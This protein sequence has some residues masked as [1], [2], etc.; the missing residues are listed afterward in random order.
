MVEAESDDA[1]AV[2]K[3]LELND[4]INTI[5]EKYMLVRKGDINAAKAL[6][7]VAPYTPAA[8][9]AK[10][11]VVED[12]LI[13]LGGDMDGPTNGS[14]SSPGPSNSSLLQTDLLGLSIDDPGP[15]FGQ[16]GGIALGFGANTSTCN[17][18]GLGWFLGLR[19]CIR[20]TGPAIAVVHIASEH[21]GTT[22]SIAIALS[23]AARRNHRPPDYI[24]VPLQPEAAAARPASRA[25]NER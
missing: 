1:E 20:Y 24:Y 16:G 18:C 17:G 6:P 14:S 8:S 11:A 15:T 13:D 10:P 2:V 9:A 23:A 25:C 4:A 3:L 7:T 12:P 22:T 19:F 5:I 21:C